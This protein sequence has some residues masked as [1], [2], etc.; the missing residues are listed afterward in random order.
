MCKYDTNK[1]T[2]KYDQK[3]G[4]QQLFRHRDYG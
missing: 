2:Y 3:K 1:I 4:F